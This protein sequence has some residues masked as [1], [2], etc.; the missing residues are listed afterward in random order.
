ML[1]AL[2]AVENLGELR[3]G[4]IRP[5]TLCIFGDA[6][7]KPSRSG[8]PGAVVNEGVGELVVQGRLD[9]ESTFSNPRTGTRIFPSKKPA[10][11]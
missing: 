11:Q 2:A 6:L 4:L 8:R 10:D 3:A 7:V 5:H 9:V 1:E